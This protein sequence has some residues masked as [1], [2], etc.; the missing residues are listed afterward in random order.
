MGI[1]LMESTCVVSKCV[2]QR[3]SEIVHF[4]YQI[5]T[6][7]TCV[8]INT[9]ECFTLRFHSTEIL[10]SWNSCS[11]FCFGQ[12]P[13]CQQDPY[14]VFA[15]AAAPTVIPQG[16]TEKG[17]KVEKLSIYTLSTCLKI[18]VMLLILSAVNI[19]YFDNFT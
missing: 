11:C 13:G 6:N 2:I 9:T 16:N 17:G 12:Q 5:S 15:T 10:D 3:C 18:T 19:R 4:F 8:F 7:N 1:Y 14:A